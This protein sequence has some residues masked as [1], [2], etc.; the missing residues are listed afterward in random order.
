[1]REFWNYATIKDTGERVRYLYRQ[2]WGRTYYSFDD[3]RTWWKSKAEAYRTTAAAGK[4]KLAE[5]V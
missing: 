2:S 3:G 1:M 5:T 4:L